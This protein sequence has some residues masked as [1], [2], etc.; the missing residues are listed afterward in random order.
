MA[1]KTLISKS[2]RDKAV[3]PPRGNYPDII[4]APV[5]NEKGDLDGEDEMAGEQDK[6]EDLVNKYEDLEAKVHEYLDNEVGTQ[7][8]SSPIVKPRQA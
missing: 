4:A 3:R 6:W 2:E 7:A 8:R 5:N 1:C